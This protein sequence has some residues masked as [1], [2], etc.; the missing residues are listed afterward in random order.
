MAD[1]SDRP[2]DD[3]ADVVSKWTFVFTLVLAVLYV[4]AVALFVR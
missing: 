2:S 3:W 4:G 1:D